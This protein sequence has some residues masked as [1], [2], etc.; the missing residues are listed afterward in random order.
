MTGL[1]KQLLRRAP[2]PSSWIFPGI[3]VHILVDETLSLQ[4]GDI[5][6]KWQH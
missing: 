5:A 2:L 3:I 1:E 4:T 6:P